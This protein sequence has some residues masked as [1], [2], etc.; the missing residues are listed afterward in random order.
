MIVKDKLFIDGQWIDPAG[1]GKIEVIEAATEQVLGTAPDGTEA[2]IDKAVVAARRAFDDGAWT[3]TT[4]AERAEIM[5]A[6]SAQI[7]GR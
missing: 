2:D 3:G 4:P 5:A 7:Q 6:L 1:S